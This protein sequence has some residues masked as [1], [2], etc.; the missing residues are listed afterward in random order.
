MIEAFGNFNLCRYIH[1]L[2]IYGCDPRDSHLHVGQVVDCGDAAHVSTTIGRCFRPFVMLEV[3]SKQGNS[4]RLPDDQAFPIGLPETMVV[5]LMTHFHHSDPAIWGRQLEWTVR[6]WHSDPVRPKELQMLVMGVNFD[7][8]LLIPAGRKR[9]VNAGHCGGKCLNR[10]NIR[11][12]HE[13]APVVLAR[14]VHIEPDDTLTVE[15]TYDSTR[16]NRTKTILYS[17]SRPDDEMCN[18]ALYT[19]PAVYHDHSHLCLSGHGQ[20]FLRR[21]SGFDN[22]TG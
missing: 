2:L 4:W 13:L 6:L 18:V 8:G 20:D 21:I 17:V 12:L 11:D 9:F 14:E 16:Y 5:N 1:D 19:H 22:C 3:M 15:C 7:A 10:H